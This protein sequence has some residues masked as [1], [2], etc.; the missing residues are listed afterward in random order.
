MIAPVT[1]E[2]VRQIQICI[3]SSNWYN[4]YTS[5]QYFYSKQLINISAPLDTI[6][7]LLGGG[8]II[9]TQKY[10]NNTKYSRENPFGLI[11]VLNKN[12]YSQDDL[13]YDDSETIDTTKKKN[14]MESKS[15]KTTKLIEDL[16]TSIEEKDMAIEEKD[17]A[18]EEKDKA[19]E[20]KDKT[21]EEKDKVIEQQANDKIQDE[22]KIKLLEDEIKLIKTKLNIIDYGKIWKLA[23]LLFGLPTL[24][25]IY[26]GK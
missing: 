26:R 24:I 8:S 5:L 25:L 15:K 10:A 1:D 20:E 17:K 12:G 16:T 23:M 9:P 3:P 14:N 7:I 21:I 6:P 11:S 18:I 4:Y 13:F 19:I 22:A 2:G